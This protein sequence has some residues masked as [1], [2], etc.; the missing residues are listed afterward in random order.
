M[1]DRVPSTAPGSSRG[2]P[3]ENIFNGT[4]RRARRAAAANGRRAVQRAFAQVVGQHLLRRS[5]ASDPVC[6]VSKKGADG[7]FKA[8]R[9][10]MPFVKIPRGEPQP[11]PTV[12]DRA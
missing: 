2:I 8:H 12:L 5:D 11:Y 6:I 3:A 9:L 7:V 1:Q 4:N 10:F